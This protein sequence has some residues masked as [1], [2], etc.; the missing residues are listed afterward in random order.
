MTTHKIDPALVRGVLGIGEVEIRI[1]DNEIVIMGDDDYPE[2]SDKLLSALS[3]RI[4]GE[5][6]VY[7]DDDGN[8]QIDI[9]RFKD[10]A[11]EW[12]AGKGWQTRGEVWNK[13]IGYIAI[14]NK[15]DE[16]VI[17]NY[18]DGNTGYNSRLSAELAAIDFCWEQIQEEITHEQEN[19]T[20]DLYLP[21]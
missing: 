9:H 15:D 3:E 13:D 2:E 4:Y 6:Y 14:C 12:C 18:P 5:N 1:Y 16:R 11:I 17:F 8:L 21:G 20:R 7:L 19:I 10:M